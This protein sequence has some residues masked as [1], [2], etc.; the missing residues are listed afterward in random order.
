MRY[1]LGR[2][3]AWIRLRLLAIDLGAFVFWHAA[4]AIHSIESAITTW[5]WERRSK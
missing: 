2:P 1:S 4:F 5:W 3:S